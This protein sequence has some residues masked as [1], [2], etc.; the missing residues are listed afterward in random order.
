VRLGVRS[1]GIVFFTRSL[2]CFTLLHTLF[3][4]DGIKVTPENIFDLLTPVALAHWICCNGS[5]QRHGLILYTDEY[6]IQEVV[7]LMNVL[8]IK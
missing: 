1:F 8:I 3:Y 2:P 6:T 7:L 4:D 5:V